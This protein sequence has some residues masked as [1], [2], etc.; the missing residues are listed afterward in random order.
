MDRIGIVL[1]AGNLGY[2]IPKDEEVRQQVSRLSIKAYAPVISHI[3]N[4]LHTQ[5]DPQM[6]LDIA[7][8]VLEPSVRNRLYQEIFRRGAENTLWI[9]PAHTRIILKLLFEEGRVDSAEEHPT[10]EGM[11]LIGQ[12]ALAIQQ[13]YLECDQSEPI[14]SGTQQWLYHYLSLKKSGTL[15]TGRWLQRQSHKELTYDQVLQ[16]K[17]ISDLFCRV[18]NTTPQDIFRG[19]VALHTVF[20]ESIASF[21][22]NSSSFS[23]DYRL[24]FGRCEVPHSAGSYIL[25]NLSYDLSLKPVLGKNAETNWGNDIQFLVDRP[26]ARLDHHRIYCLDLECL[27]S[28]YSRLI[29]NL[30]TRMLD[31]KEANIQVRQMAG[32]IL[33]DTVQGWLK[34]FGDN[35]PRSTLNSGFTLRDDIQVDGVVVE[36]N[37]VVL[38]EVKSGVLP[39]SLTLGNSIQKLASMINSKY[40]YGD[41]KGLS[42]FSQL[43]RATE[44]ILNDPS[45]IGLKRVKHIYI[46]LL[47]EDE[48]LPMKPA[49]LYIVNESHKMFKSLGKRVSDPI[50]LH[51]DDLRSLAIRCKRYSLPYMM[52]RMWRE[53]FAGFSFGQLI[54]ERLQIK[55][56]ELVQVEQKFP[57][58]DVVFDELKLGLSQVELKCS[59]C[60]GFN[61]QYISRSG[62]LVHKCFRCPG[63]EEHLVSPEEIDA[64]RHDDEKWIAKYREAAV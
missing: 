19:V 15:I 21:S 18:Y 33:E 42:G 16:N 34:I 31:K 47:V 2:R 61:K 63:A 6:Q 57:L 39:V 43:K 49:A 46:V 59:N 24:L 56:N 62:S 5:L 40:I 35:R 27:R 22:R 37:E 36:D 41:S 12:I 60:G 38:F 23:V 3:T 53:G 50:I 51:V 4:K 14:P 32:T 58:T 7:E 13:T 9:T 52:K 25:E 44:M 64:M 29:F 30:L 20:S 45:L 11:Y 48:D 17:Q 1:G 10:Q 55:E 8:R 54:E 26:L 28:T